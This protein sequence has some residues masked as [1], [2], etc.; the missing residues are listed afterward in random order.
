MRDGCRTDG[1]SV[2]PWWAGLIGRACAFVLCALLVLAVVVSQFVPYILKLGTHFPVPPFPVLLFVGALVLLL[3]WSLI[4]RRVRG[5]EDATSSCVLALT[6]LLAVVQLW[7]VG[8]YHFVTGWDSGTVSEAAWQIATTGGVPAGSFFETYISTYPNNLFLTWFATWCM[9]ASVALGDPSE[10]GGQ[11]V[12]VALNC[13]SNAVTCWCVYRLVALLANGRLAL[14]GWLLAE[15]ILLVSPWA[16]IMYSDSLVVGVSGA[17]ALNYAEVRLWLSGGA[18]RGGDVRHA[19]SGRPVERG[20]VARAGAPAALGRCL[21]MGLL[22]VVGYDLKPQSAFVLLAIAVVEALGLAG[23]VVASLRSRRLPACAGRA[24]L[25]V[26]G[27]LLGVLLAMGATTLAEASLG[28]PVDGDA[29]FGPAHFLLMGSNE[30]RLGT[31]YGPDVD[32]SASLPTRQ[33]RT[34]GDLER[35]QQRVADYGPVW[36][37]WLL[38]RK[39]M[40]TYSDGTFS[41]GIEDPFFDNLMPGP[42]DG[43][44][45]R[46]AQALYLPD[47]ALCPLWAS[48]SQALWLATLL[49]CALAGLRGHA[50]DADVRGRVVCALMLTV[51]GLTLFEM[52]FEARA[53]Y[54]YSSLPVFVTLAMLGLGR[55]DGLVGRRLRAAQGANV[56]RLARG[57]VVR[58]YGV[59]SESRSVY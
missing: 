59:R 51:L 27:V 11:L 29:A 57:R 26:A 46:L 37:A 22:G 17:I 44:V 52:L 21:L 1:T 48:V 42:S 18:H 54:L 4:R 47:G 35:Y 9:R 13:V 55:L 58:P 33:E 3:V 31:Y 7:F 28:I 25:C 19:V 43:L 14:M 5:G 16:S 32:F 41:W 56:T 34:Q 30:E 39:A 53:R 49:L 23:S 2:A 38:V 45:R 36:Y 10:L 8:S 6:V 15:A 20:R 40:M 12:F 50:G 24:L